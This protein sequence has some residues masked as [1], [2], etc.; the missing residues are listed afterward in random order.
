MRDVGEVISVNVAQPRTLMRRGRELPTGLWKLPVE[1][2]VTVGDLG[3]DGD[4]Q[5]DKRVHGGPDKAVYAYAIEDVEWWEE[6]LGRG[7]GPGFFGENLTF[8]A[9]DV[10][11]ARIG[12]RWEIGGTVLEVSEPRHPCWKLATKVGDPRF[13]KRFAQAGRPG[14]YLRVVR[15]GELRVGDVVVVTPGPPDAPSIAAD[16]APGG[17]LA[18][19]SAPA[20]RR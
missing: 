14:A 10:S 16:A 9:V 7:L 1:G 17:S 6:Q 20:A 12:E 5:A 18:A 8:R 4:L 15:Q 13:I 2:A 19:Q 11:G 3:L